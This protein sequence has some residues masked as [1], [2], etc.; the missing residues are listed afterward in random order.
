M[1]SKGRRLCLPGCDASPEAPAEVVG[2]LLSA[3]LHEYVGAA[4]RQDYVALLF[5][6]VRH[7]LKRQEDAHTGAG[8]DAHDL[9]QVNSILE[10]RCLIEDEEDWATGTVELSVLALEKLTEEQAAHRD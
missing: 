9:A 7:L 1:A 8:G 10:S 5:L 6:E 2:G 3:A 4:I